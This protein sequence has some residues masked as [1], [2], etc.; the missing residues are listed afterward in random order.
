MEDF[1][2]F[3]NDNDETQ[4]TFTND[5]ETLRLERRDFARASDDEVPFHIPR[6]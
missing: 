3:M 6:D 5:D 2:K 4:R 1:R